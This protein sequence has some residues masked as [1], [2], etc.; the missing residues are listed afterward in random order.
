MVI[1]GECVMMCNY[2]LERDLDIS[3][4]LSFALART[5]TPSLVFLTLP[6]RDGSSPAIDR[7]FRVRFEKSRSEYLNQLVHS[8][9]SAP[10]EGWRRCS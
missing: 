9:A 6:A 7:N 1:W 3:L 10:W 2:L 8:S 4:I 5:F